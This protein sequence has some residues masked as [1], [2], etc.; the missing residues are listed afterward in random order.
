M[1]RFT[2]IIG[3]SDGGNTALVLAHR[4][5]ERVERL[6]AISANYDPSGL[7]D[8]AR[9]DA[10][11]TSNPLT[12]WLTRWWT[13]AGPRAG[14]LER[15]IKRM[16]LSGPRLTAQDLTG[17]R[18][19]VLVIAGGRDVILQEHAE[20]MAELIPEAR[21]EVMAVGGHSL[22]VTH[23]DWVNREISVFLRVRMR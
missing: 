5:P 6:V 14:E 10:G 13:E 17:I 18:L 20:A 23:P 4:W 9:A 16:W 12:H 3:W 19:P 11:R 7:T 21:L 8:A 15:R 2:T 1:P 22:P